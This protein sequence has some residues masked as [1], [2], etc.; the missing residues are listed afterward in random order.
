MYKILRIF[1]TII[2]SFT[3]IMPA[4]SQQKIHQRIDQP[5]AH[6]RF[7]RGDHPTTQTDFT[8]TMADG[9]I[10]DCTQ[11][12]AS[13]TPPAGGWPSMVFCHGFGGTK[14]EVM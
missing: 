11:F 1:L 6:K 3:I 10:I 2:V 13:G 8:L 12:T 5:S 9:T 7:Q 14:D 4:V